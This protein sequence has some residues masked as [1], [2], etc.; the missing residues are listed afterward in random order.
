M[1]LSGVFVHLSTLLV[2][3]LAI[4]AAPNSGKNS[5][6][7]SG[8]NVIQLISDGFGPASETFTRS[9]LQSKDKTN[10]TVELPLDKFLV[11]NVRTRSTDSLVTDSA[12]S[13]TAYSCGLKSVNAYIGVDTEK[14]PCGTVLEAAKA[15]GYNVALVSTSRITHA[16][17]A[18][19]SAHVDDRDAEDEIA[20]QQIGNYLLGKQV[21]ILWGGGRRHF[22]PNTTSPGIRTDG[23][24]LVAQAKSEGWTYVSNKMEFDTFQGGKNVSFPSLGL[25]TASHMS[26]EIDRNATEEP[27]LKEMALT[28]LTALAQADAPY[29]IMIEGAR[30]DHAAHNNDPIGHVHDILAYNEMV[31]AVTEWMDEQAKQDAEDET[32]LF[33]VADHECGGLTLGLERREDEEAFYGWF[34]DVLFNA[35]HSTEYLA[36]QIGKYMK[37]NNITTGTPALFDYIKNEVVIKSLGVAD[38]Q[39]DEVQRAVD[40]AALGSDAAVPLTVWLSSILNWRAHLGW[41]TTGHSGVD[42]NLYFHESPLASKNKKKVSAYRSRRDSVTGSHENT[43]IGQ[44][45]AKYLDLDLQSITKK[46]NNG[47]DYSW[48][49]NW[50]DRLNTFTENLEH[51]HGGL[52]RVIPPNP[53]SV[54]A[55]GKGKRSEL[56]SLPESYLENEHI[57]RSIHGPR[58][59]LSTAEERSHANARRQEL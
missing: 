44:W 19:Y 53:A 10:W 49:N 30:I 42:V 31:E 9:Y 1:K 18:S 56:A 14:K 47:S 46:L 26:Y 22:L 17:P 28:A 5:K 16:T 15:K 55:I 23:K 13:A 3:A 11:G 4:E 21:D 6:R 59:H 7:A 50:S 2:V 48:A 25:F 41:S 54:E 36:G 12:A 40:L 27:S 57:L 39:D 52:A 38:V 24:D 33:S 29:F 32:V 58:K 51:Y 43:W 45:I 35:T 20:N 34:P 8:P 37:A